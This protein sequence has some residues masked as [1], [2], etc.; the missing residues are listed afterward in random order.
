MKHTD[1]FFGARMNAVPFIPGIVEHSEKLHGQQEIERKKLDRFKG[2]SFA[3]R[4][5]IINKE[6]F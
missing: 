1:R 6:G 2:L 4:M 3:E 5:K